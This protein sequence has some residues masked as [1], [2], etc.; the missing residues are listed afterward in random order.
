MKNFFSPASLITIA[1]AVLT[2]IGGSAYLASAPNLSLPTLFYGFPIFLAG[3]A[4][5]SSE[6]PPAKKISSDNPLLSKAREKGPKE[7]T[8]LLKD[9]TKWKYGQNAHLESS[10]KALKLWDDTAPPQLLEIEELLSEDGYGVRLRFEIAGV[11]LERWEEKK[12][13]LGRFFASGLEA[14]LVS[15]SNTELDLLILP[16]QNKIELVN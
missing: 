13:R 2:V 7:L 6:L 16:K 9:V 15:P 3:L 5:K 8:K 11:D 12:E 4:L 10:L 1:G 14:Q